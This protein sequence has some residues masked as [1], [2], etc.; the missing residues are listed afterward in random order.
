MFKRG[1]V[2]VGEHLLP[3]DDV[4]QDLVQKWKKFG[5]STQSTISIDFCTRQ[6]QHLKIMALA[7]WIVSSLV[8]WINQLKKKNQFWK[9]I[10]LYHPAF[11]QVAII[12]FAQL[13]LA[14][15]VQAVGVANWCLSSC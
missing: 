6:S 5:K 1:N 12:L 4:R 2:L 7:L 8:L 15:P 11:Q 9:I 3:D 13:M 14:K 10:V